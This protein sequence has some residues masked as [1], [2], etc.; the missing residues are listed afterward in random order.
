METLTTHENATLEKK[1]FSGVSLHPDNAIFQY[2]TARF[3]FQS[4]YEQLM[5]CVGNPGS[6]TEKRIESLQEKLTVTSFQTWL[7]SKHF[8]EGNQ[9]RQ[10]S[11]NYNLLLLT[12]IIDLIELVKIQSSIALNWT[13]ENEEL[14]K[15][16]L[17]EIELFLTR[18]S[19]EYKERRL[20]NAIRQSIHTIKTLTATVTEQERVQLESR[21]AELYSRYA[22]LSPYWKI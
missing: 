13:L 12:G 19:D 6:L 21:M 4:I 15:I 1:L 2:L 10:G 5:C 8:H 11:Y 16:E 14:N 20:R 7:L 22:L 17:Q 18:I 3:H 9:L